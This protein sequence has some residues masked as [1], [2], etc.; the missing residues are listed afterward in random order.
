MNLIRSTKS[1]RIKDK[2]DTNISHLE[3]KEVVFVH[4]IIVSNDRQYIQESSS[5]NS[6][7][8]EVWFTDQNSKQLEIEHNYK[9]NITY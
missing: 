6:D 7:L 3:I 9:Y 4:C 5:F 1:K 2:N 8:F